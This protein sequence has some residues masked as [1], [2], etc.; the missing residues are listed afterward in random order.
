LN[1]RFGIK[2]SHGISEE[3]AEK[4]FKQINEENQNDTGEKKE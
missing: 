1:K 4:V 3:E 2:V